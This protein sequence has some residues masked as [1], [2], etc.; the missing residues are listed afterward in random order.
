[1]ADVVKLSP[2]TQRELDGESAALDGDGLLRSNAGVIKACEHNARVLIAAAPQYADLPLVEFLSRMRLGGRY[3]TDADDIECVCWLQSEHG[4]AR[5][6]LGHAR[7]AARVVAHSRGR[8]SLREFVEELPAW[9]GIERID[10]AFADAW[11]AASRAG[12]I[13]ARRPAGQAAG[14][15]P[16]TLVRPGTERAKNRLRLPD[17]RRPTRW[18]AQQNPRT[19]SASSSCAFRARAP[20]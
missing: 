9:D 17:P 1:M 10:S 11:R 7:S 2:R 6:T 20:P 3:G 15:R 12:R 13:S 8:D 5:F 16:R 19:R 18:Q 4:V 14:M